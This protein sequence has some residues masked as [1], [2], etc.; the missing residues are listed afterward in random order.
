MIP[1]LTSLTN[2]DAPTLATLAGICFF[3]GVVRGFA[4]FALS[5]LVMSS[6]VLLLPPVELIPICWM[7]EVAASGLMLRGGFRDANR[8]MVLTLV[9]G[10]AIGAPIGLFLTTKLPVEDSKIVVLVLVVSLATLQLVRLR[11][12]GLNTL[13]GTWATGLT[14]GLV[15]GL[16][17]LGGM[18]IALFVMARD[19]P[20]RAM[21][22]SLVLFLLLSSFTTMIYLLSFG[23]M[24]HQ[25][26]LRGALFMVPSSLGVFLGSRLF[27]PRLVPWYR[28]LCLTLLIG[29]ALLSLWRTLS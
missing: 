16:A 17:L 27:I 20:A 1:W 14:A 7:L 2:L 9:V 5:A 3:A 25:A 21:R 26:A 12:P 8:P 28:P 4:G 22:A 19:L 15:T 11:P 24:D 10:S 13:A 18:V 23:L 29:L 6:G